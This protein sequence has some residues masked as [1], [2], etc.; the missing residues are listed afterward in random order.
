M[1]SILFSRIFYRCCISH[2]LDLEGSTV[3]E[4][5]IEDVEFRPLR[6]TPDAKEHP[7]SWV[8]SI[9]LID[10]RPK[11]GHFNFRRSCF[12]RRIPQRLY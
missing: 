12:L 3:D 11:L 4:E 2:F 1:D 6:E 9:S 5:V 10:M 7:I 8:H